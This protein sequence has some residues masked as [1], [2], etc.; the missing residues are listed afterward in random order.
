MV[1][2]TRLLWIMPRLLDHTQCKTGYL[3]KGGNINYVLT[4]VRISF[5]IEHP[6]KEIKNVY[7]TAEKTKKKGII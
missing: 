2:V 3:A 7:L 6:Q 1:F 5:G 4:A